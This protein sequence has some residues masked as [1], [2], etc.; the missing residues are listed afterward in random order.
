MREAS[1]RHKSSHVNKNRGDGDRTGDETQRRER[2]SD[3]DDALH[4]QMMV[5]HVAWSSVTQM[6]VPSL[7]Y[8][9]DTSALANTLADMR[10]QNDWVHH[11][12]TFNRM[13]LNHSK[14][15]LIG[16]DADGEPVTAA[17]LAAAGITIDGNALQPVPHDQ[18]IRYLGVHMSF[19]GSWAAQQ[20][21]AVAKTAMFQRAVTKFGVTLKQAVYMYN[22]FLMPMLELALHYMHGPGTAAC[23][24]M[25]DRLIIG[26]IKHAVSSPLMLSHTAVALSIDLLLPSWLETSVKSSELFLRMNDSDARWGELGRVL[27]R[28]S[29]NSVMDEHTV[30]LRSDGGTRTS[31]AVHLAVKS[32][33]WSLKLQQQR[34]ATD[35]HQHLFDQ[36]A[37]D[38]SMPDLAQCSSTSMHALAAQPTRLPMER[39]GHR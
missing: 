1:K 3:V 32:L 31:R 17:A 10:V 4:E 5:Q 29:V 24:K 20:S 2:P 23:I 38:T 18:P 11:F 34:R 39:L 15:E 13:R 35:R 16:R 7:V 9:N 27:M 21:K 6:D 25:C 8:A 26:S 37:L 28:Q 36:S 22:V 33:G 12:M 19:D 14:C 30:S